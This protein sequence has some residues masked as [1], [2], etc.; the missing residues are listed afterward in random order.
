M[1]EYTRTEGSKQNVDFDSSL[2]LGH[3][4]FWRNAFRMHSLQK[5][6]SK[7]QG[8]HKTPDQN[9]GFLKNFDRDWL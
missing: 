4:A 5:P 1:C 9:L 7:I 8:S 3:S 2:Y 6:R